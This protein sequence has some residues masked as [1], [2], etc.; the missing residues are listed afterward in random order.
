MPH[1]CWPQIN[2]RPDKLYTLEEFVEDQEKHRERV[3]YANI[4][5]KVSQVC[6][7]VWTPG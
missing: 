5:Q 1:V 6:G 7:R 3:T 4:Q 2:N